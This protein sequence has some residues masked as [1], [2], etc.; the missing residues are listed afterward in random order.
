MTAL[1]GLWHFDGRPAADRCARMLA[2]QE[3]Y[4]PDARGQ[5][6]D[7]GVALGRQLMRLL[8]EDS[9]DRQPLVGGGGRLVLVA[10]VRLDNRDELAAA[11]DIPAAAA[12]GLC[13]AAI[14]LTALERWDDA[15]FSR[16]VGD[17]AFALWDG[18]R[19]RLL[20]ARDP[21]GQKP[22]HIHRG[23]GFFAFA[24]MPKG[25]HALPDVP[26]APDEEM[27]LEFLAVIPK[28]GTRTF[29]RDIERVEPGHVTT[30]T[31]RGVASRPHWEP[32]RRTIRLG[33]AD[34]Y[35][36]ALRHHLDQAVACRL[37][38]AADVGAQLSGGLDSGAVAATAARLLAPSGR[39]VVAFTAVPRA[40][41]DGPAPRNRF[42]DE[43]PHAAAT[44]AMHPNME[45][46]L[47]RPARKLLDDLD[48]SLFLY[49]RPMLNL[50][51]A[52]W[53]HAIKDAARDRKLNVLLIGLMGNMTL[54]Y[55]GL[56]LLPELIRGGRW[57][58]WCR[59]ARAQVGPG[60]MRWRGAL[61][62]TFGPW[63]PDAVW[64]RLRQWNGGRDFEIAQ[65]AAIH[66]DVR[67]R[68]DLAALARERGLDLLARMPKDGFAARLRALRRD[69]ANYNK[70]T[71]AGWRIDQRDPTTDVRLVE[72]CLAV[73]A[74]MYLR[75][76]TQRALAR[77]A[78]ADRLPPRVLDER[79][80]GYQA[81]D[82]HERLALARGQVD[83][84]LDRLAGCPPAAKVL[85]LERM[86]RLVALWPTGGWERTDVMQNYR[87]ALL[88]GLS[89]GHFLRRTAGANR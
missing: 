59:E 62:N 19:R 35:A 48:R 84:E 4:G 85:D 46:V 45:H 78:F 56:D 21:L 27:V 29:Y 72:F 65:Y 12:Q 41:Y 68:R 51:N 26:R 77:R 57:L 81:A 30:V 17:Y 70:G 74:E 83:V 73:P 42:N 22:L 61:A 54:S 1:A 71:L 8:P 3:L 10:D 89:T 39:R 69:T 18:T 75:D 76:G 6:S 87:L 23:N 36:E 55:A 47:V 20:L 25:L 43:G 34:E 88:R 38:G 63:V 15:C 58:R 11:L 50:C 28:I 49:D 86:R 79:R 24:S 44:A 32:Q 66:P 40:G 37:R 82:W 31:E 33:S 53:D 13:D 7:G 16:L 60:K 9:F 80:K 52:E 64:T 67:A 5:W 2:A 14:L